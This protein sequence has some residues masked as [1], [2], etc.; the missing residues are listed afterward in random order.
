MSERVLSRNAGCEDC[1]FY[2]RWTGRMTDDDRCHARSEKG[3]R[4]TG[5]DAPW[6]RRP[7]WCPL[8]SGPATVR[9]AP[10]RKVRP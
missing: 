6:P 5:D 10:E 9:L 2:R 7:P 3:R 8:E 1:P 4:I